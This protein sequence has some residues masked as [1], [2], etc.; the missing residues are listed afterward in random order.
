MTED[1]LA[2]CYRTLELAPGASLTEIK[3]AYNRLKRLYGEE[4]PLLRVMTSD[5]PAERRPA[6]LAEVEAAY[7]EI[8]ASINVP[9]E[10]RRPVIEPEPDRGAVLTTGAGLRRRRESLGL[11]LEGIRQV[12]KIRAEILDNIESERFETL[13]DETFLR[14]HLVQYARSLGLNPKEVLDQYIGR[15]QEWKKRR[16]RTLGSGDE[17]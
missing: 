3:N 16:A 14:N 5:F 9:V 10:T 4:T 15:Y 2:A 1:K 6:I 17:D 13:P 8:L 12:T 11:T 7:H